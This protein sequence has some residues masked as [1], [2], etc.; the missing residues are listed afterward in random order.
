MD[1]GLT[2]AVGTNLSM[3]HQRKRVVLLSGHYY[4][5]KRRGG[6]HWLADAYRE[7]GW[8]V[9]FVTT[10]VSLLSVM[11]K[12]RR[13]EEPLR[14]KAGRFETFRPGVDSFVLF[15]PWHPANL[16]NGFLN[17]LS[18]PIYR[19][20]GFFLPAA[21]RERLAAA[22]LIIFESNPSLLLFNR[23]ARIAPKARL[24]YRVSDD[25]RN[26]CVHPVVL[27]VEAE[28]L[29]R[30]HLVSAQARS[31]E[32][33]FR[34]QARVV[35]HLPAIDKAAFDV[36]VANPYP[37]DGRP[38]VVS[39][40][41]SF[42]DYDY[43]PA[44]AAHFPQC[45][46]H[47]IGRLERTFDAPNITW[48]GELPFARMLP[49]M[50][51]ADVGLALYECREGGESLADSSHKLTQYTYCRLPIVAPGFACRPDRPHILPYVN[52]DAGS[53]K[54]GLE[55]ALRFP[56]T[57]VTAESVRSWTEMARELAGETL[58]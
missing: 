3:S 21:L 33:R 38:R 31:V 20:Y 28:I 48:H 23:I 42:F 24:V 11:K 37:N 49:F 18:G 12:D 22:D 7:L 27:D 4:G 19:G 1:A 55:A 29:S 9:L 43:L 52:G 41:S 51:H 26:L 34:D 2:A 10:C 30:F 14:E 15:T 16:R 5:S 46:F 32:R 8:D 53:M 25:L 17:A 57:Q 50:K 58:R 6:F 47:V 39:V 35:T 13:L 45:Q 36:D 44:V 40:G 56:K 54:S